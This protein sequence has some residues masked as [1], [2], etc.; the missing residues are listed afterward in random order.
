M[1][2]ERYGRCDCGPTLTS[3]VQEQQ[4][5]NSN[6]TL[7]VVVINLDKY[8]RYTCSSDIYLSFKED[9]AAIFLN[10]NLDIVKTNRK[11]LKLYKNPLV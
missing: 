2:K 3:W 10:K 6:K 7:R 9:C 1:Q 11:I 5:R 4:R 8:I